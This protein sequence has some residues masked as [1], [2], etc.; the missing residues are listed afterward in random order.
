MP[1]ALEATHRYEITRLIASGGMGTVYQARQHGSAGFAKT[2]AIK[3]IISR[4]AADREL[5]RLII[6]EAKLVADLVHENIVQVY[7][8]GSQDDRHFIVMEYVD[9]INLEH[10]IDH[11]VEC[12]RPL[13]IELGAFIMSRVCRGL[14]YAHNRTGR[15]D[16][17][18]GI[19]H[20]D[21]SPK[22]VLLNFE[23][24]V[25][26][27][28]F[29]IAKARQVMEQDEG[30]LMGRM[31]YMSPEQAQRRVTDRRSDIY[32]VGVVLYELLTGTLPLRGRGSLLRSHRLGTSYARPAQEV[33][34]ELPDRLCRII[35]QA[36]RPNPDERYQTAGKMGYDLE[37][38]LYHGGFGPT[39]VTLG[40]YLKRHL[41]EAPQPTTRRQP[42]A[43]AKAQTNQLV[44]QRAETVFGQLL[45]EQPEEQEQD[46]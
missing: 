1:D 15:D 24:V 41:L 12:S 26:V 25:K 6:A 40:D 14:D 37:Y 27:T 28:D 17:E 39:N 23:G 10:F 4:F 34:A 5:T 30:V 7:N 38:F 43:T 2:V 18:L 35:E 8:L 44:C 13:P 36:L 19:V 22:N 42:A 20:R 33:R 31:E 32:A 11:H 9:G 46:R 21:I 29:G 45:D 3:E 16:Q